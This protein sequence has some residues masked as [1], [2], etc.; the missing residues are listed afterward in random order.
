[1]GTCAVQLEKANMQQ[2]RRTTDKK[3]KERKYGQRI[4]IDV[5]QKDTQMPNK[6][7]KLYLISESAI[8]KFKSKLQQDITPHTPGKPL[9]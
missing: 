7:R 1:M 4:R 6:N 3:R 8:R 2:G 5:S 9:Y